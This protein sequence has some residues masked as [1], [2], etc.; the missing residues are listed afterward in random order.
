MT[1]QRNQEVHFTK[2]PQ[3]LYGTVVNVIDEGQGQDPSVLVQPCTVRCHA[4]DLES[5]ELPEMPE[6]DTDR[7]SR[8]L[9]GPLGRIPEQW[10]ADP[11]NPELQSKMLELLRELGVIKPLPKT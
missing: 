6:S 2:V 1:F 7:F 5:A 11:E 8:V 10:A 3:L 9:G 4:S